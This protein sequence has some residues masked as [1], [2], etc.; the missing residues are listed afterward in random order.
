MP[1]ASPKCWT[2]LGSRT[3]R[4]AEEAD[5]DSRSQ[6]QDRLR[7]M[8]HSRPLLSAMILPLALL[9][10]AM[11]YAMGNAEPSAGSS[12]SSLELGVPDAGPPT[13]APRLPTRRCGTRPCAASAG[14]CSQR[15]APL[16]PA[17]HAVRERIAGA[18]QAPPRRAA[19]G[20]WAS[21]RGAPHNESGPPGQLTR[22][23]KDY[24][25]PYGAA[26]VLEPSTGRVLALAEHSQ[27][28]PDMRGLTTRAVFPPP[29]SSRSSPAARCSRR[30]CRPSRR[31]ASTVASGASPSGSW[32][33]ASA[34]APAIRSLMPWARA[35]TSSSPR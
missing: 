31:P 23:M 32:R 33:T 29:A 24:Q 11:G 1:P 27:A 6:D 28:Q 14:A 22:I 21:R 5:V 25:V 4:A 2:S 34:M 20:S 16:L 18:R 8:P 35:P 9:L 10:G 30:A 26:V 17:P 13:R 7:H 12:A 3:P 19:R 15:L